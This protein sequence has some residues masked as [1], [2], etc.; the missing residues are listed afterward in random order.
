MRHVP[1][2]F[3][4]SAALVAAPLLVPAAAD[5]SSALTGLMANFSV[6][7]SWSG[8][9]EGNYTVTN[10]SSQTVNRWSLTFTLPVGEAVTDVWDGTLSQS[11]NTY[12]ITSPTWA[13]PLA[14][15]DSFT[16][17]GM[18]ISTGATQTPPAGC[19]INSGPPIGPPSRGLAGASRTALPQPCA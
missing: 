8:G 13:S 14:P 15:G 12:T 11:G 19:T 17:V 18:N 7:Q 1:L 16:D 2:R 3:V 5:A 9:L 4:A 6:A 10:N